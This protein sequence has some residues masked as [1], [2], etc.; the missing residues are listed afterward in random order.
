MTPIA[1]AAG[2]INLANHAL[3]D[4]LFVIGFENFSDKLMAGNTAE[5]V[6]AALQFNVGIADAT[7]QQTHQRGSGTTPRHS[8]FDN[9]NNSLIQMNS[10]HKVTVSKLESHPELQ[11]P[12]RSARRK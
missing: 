9:A 7:T 5:T 2:K 6:V 12:G 4:K 10:E 8:A 1:F 3:A 11:L